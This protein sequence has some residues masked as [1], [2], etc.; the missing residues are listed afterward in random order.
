[1]NT[2]DKA[3]YDLALANLNE[4]KIENININVL[5]YVCRYHTC[6]TCNKV[7]DRKKMYAD[8]SKFF[9]K[10]VVNT[11]LQLAYAINKVGGITYAKWNSYLVACRAADASINGSRVELAKGIE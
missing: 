5:E 11:V 1:M 8:L 9:N 6:A 2:H 10:E 4:Q 7:Q 3:F